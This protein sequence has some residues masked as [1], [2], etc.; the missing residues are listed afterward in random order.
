MASFDDMQLASEDQPRAITEPQ[1]AVPSLNI[2]LGS[3]PAF[4][5]LEAM[6]QLIYLPEADRRRVALV[7]LDIDTAPAEVAQFRQEHPGL[8]LEFDL[9]IGVAHGVLYAD[10][11]DERIASHTYIPTKIPESFD[12]GAG[13]IRNNGHVA[14]CTDHGKIVQLLDEALSALG[15]LSH[16]RGAH[17]VT[18]IQ[19]NIVAF[20]GGGTG[21]GVLP[22]IAVMTRHRVLQLN[23]KHRLNIFCLLP[24]HVREATTNDVS[25]RKSNATATLLELCALSLAR[26]ERRADGGYAPYLKYMLNTP[27]EVRG[28]TI[29]NEVY[30]FGQ[31]AMASAENA[32]RIIGLD[33]YTRI[34]NAS[35]VGF[36]ERSKSVDRRTL[37][38]YD[39]A[40]LPTMF[41]TT[42]P[43]EIAFPAA[44]TATAFAQ[45]TAARVLPKLAGKLEALSYELSSAELQEVREWEHALEP[46]DL[47]R[48]TDR[49]FE[50]AGRDRLHSLE[51]RLKEQVETVE[52]GVAEAARQRES[53]EIRALTGIHL[54]PL[55]EQ[56]RRLS[57]KRK[58]YQAALHH[59]QE[60]KIPRKARPD[61]DLQRKLLHAWPVLGLKDKAVAAV[62]DDF[63]GVQRRNVRAVVLT[64]RRQ[65]LQRLIAYLDERLA[66]V[67]GYRGGIDSGEVTRRLE[68]QATTSAAWRGRLDNLHVHRRH[69]FD[70]PGLAG[71]ETKDGAS[72]PVKQLY[73]Y[74]TPPEVLESL[75]ASFTKWFQ[76]K[77]RDEAGLLA[78]DP[79]DLRDRVVQYLRDE[80]YLSA[81][82]S[83]NFFDLL[84]LCCVRQGE[85]AEAKVEDIL[86]AHLQHI[87][88]LARDLV[89]F[90]DQLWGDGTGN[91]ATSLYLGVHYRDGSQRRILDRARARLATVAR[92]GSAPMLAPAIDPHRLQ[93]VYGQHAI[94]LGTIPDFYQEANSSM[95]E[96]RFHESAWNRDFA[97]EYGA[98]NAPVFS[99]GE[100]ERL[101]MKDFAAFPNEPDGLYVAQ[102]KRNLP[103]RVIRRPQPGAGARPV[104]NGNGSVPASTHRQPPLTAPDSVGTGSPVRPGGQWDEYG[105]RF[106]E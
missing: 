55:G 103:E 79:G 100:M 75:P 64:Q 27:Y 8:L 6:R 29:A 104:W 52:E 76:E 73:D 25:W 22:D 82:K 38:N 57:A 41:G 15:A 33:L 61:A 60:Q 43:M 34:T 2:F 63:N 97:P 94:S 66:K 86:F 71:M 93:L 89:A 19:I 50:T 35:G 18:E 74:L 67:T 81:L 13:G 88:G 47:P 10:A 3:T 39:A 96:F 69:L 44:E 77:Y 91:L 101:V 58:I 17:P 21:S 45:L 20:L 4:S 85:R 28:S 105:R 84:T 102:P 51:A 1:V 23:L 7:F 32:A 30:L 9:R 11:L 95:G 48:F 26:G 99:C 37:G 70:L 12:N 59:V 16:E 62:T 56:I 5:A 24:E 72:L 68:T 106:T 87:G 36:L 31:T 14:A 78:V 53:D 90:E 65:L 98:S 80:V 54:L 40:G 42:C 46:P 92:Q 83:M 49:Q